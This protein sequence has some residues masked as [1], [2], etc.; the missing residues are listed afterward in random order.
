MCIRDTRTGGAGVYTLHAPLHPS[1]DFV[2][3][4]L[5][6]PYWPSVPPPDFQTFRHLCAWVKDFQFST[7]LW[8]ETAMLLQP[9]CAGC[10]LVQQRK[11]LPGI[12]STFYS[13]SS[14]NNNNEMQQNHDFIRTYSLKS[15]KIHELYKYNWFFSSRN[16]N[17]F[18]KWNIR[19]CKSRTLELSWQVAFLYNADFL[20]STFIDFT[21]SVW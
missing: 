12:F 10:W 5:Y 16:H 8:L 18:L 6:Q 15:L 3:L 21:T 14:Q 13:M 17:P 11:T 1:S 19:L 7:E 9:W 2:R 20:A 4:T